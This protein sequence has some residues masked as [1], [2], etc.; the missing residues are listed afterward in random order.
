MLLYVIFSN[1]L[2]LVGCAK[3]FFCTRGFFLFYLF[4]SGTDKAKLGLIVF[5]LSMVSVED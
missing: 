5:V 4:Q 1:R 3:F 2:N